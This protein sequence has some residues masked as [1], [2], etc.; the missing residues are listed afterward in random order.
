M[1]ITFKKDRAIF[2]EV[3]GGDDAE[4]LLE[5]LQKYPKGKIDLSACT[6]LQPANLQVLMAAKCSIVA[7]PKDEHLAAWINTALKTN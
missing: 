1:P 5:W 2:S 4:S 6:H 3:A 7:R